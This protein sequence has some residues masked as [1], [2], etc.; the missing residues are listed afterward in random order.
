MK[1]LVLLD[2]NNGTKLLAFGAREAL[3]VREGDALEHLDLFVEQH[4]GNYIFGYLSYDLKNQ[5]EKLSSNN[6]SF[7]DLPLLHFFVP[8]YVVELTGENTT[9]L[10][11][12]KSKEAEVFLDSFFQASTQSGA[13]IDL[14]PLQ[15]KA[16][17]LEA[18]TAIQS[19]LTRGD[20]YE[21]TY[22]QAFYAEN[23]ALDSKSIF[24]RLN[25]WT[26]APFATYLV[27]D[28]IHLMC[29]SPERFLKRE[30]RKLTTQPI[31]GT[32]KRGKT[33]AEDEILKAELRNSAKEQA[34]NVMIVDL[35][36]NDLSK[37][38]EKYSVKVEELF[39]VYSFKTV[40]QLISSVSA[41]HE[42]N[43]S[44]G[45]IF[46]A[47]FPMGSMTGAPKVKSMELIEE[48]ETFQ[49]GLFSG[50]VGYIAPN[51][52]FDFNVV[53][54]SILYNP[55]TKTVVCPVG[56]AITLDADPSAEYEECLLKANAMV[57]VLKSDRD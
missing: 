51:G 23:V 43:Q 50:S 4:K 54:R 37:I 32:V 3:C 12:E 24:N 30:G 38:A 45:D 53:I 11:G 21:V 36:R 19:H 35:V 1:P 28:D 9:F 25:A 40:H 52:D 42:P 8:N 5:L 49:R 34:E 14:T 29:G 6:K 20:S 47:L 27:T 48:Y 18:V 10:Q 26:A 7:F 46:K 41:V 13:G 22:C 56:G 57:K 31:K 33:A 39:G 16:E 17:Y 15:S 44:L 2:K 55:I